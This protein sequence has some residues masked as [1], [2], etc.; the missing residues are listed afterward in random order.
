[1]GYDFKSLTR[2]A[3]EA[4]NRNKFYID[5]EDVDPTVLH[6]ITDLT[7]W[8]RTKGKGSDVREIIAQLFER[9]W[10]E[11]MKEGNANFEVAKSR[12]DFDLLPDRLDS[13]AANLRDKAPI[14]WVKEQLENMT[15]GGPIA[16]LKDLPAIQSTYPD[17]A[18][19]IVVAKGNG[20]WYF[21]SKSSRQWQDGGL[22]KAQGLDKDEVSADNVDFT[23]GVKQM[24]DLDSAFQG[25]VHSWTGTKMG[26]YPDSSTKSYPALRLL[27]NKTYYLKDIRGVFSYY[28]SLDG[29]RM[30]RKF[31][32]K[33][34]VVTTDFTPS[35][36]GLLYITAPT[37]KTPQVFSASLYQLRS[38]GV[39]LNKIYRGYISIK[40][41]KLEL[42]VDAEDLS[43]IRIIK[44]LLDESAI[45]RG[46]YYTGNKQG[47]AISATWGV[48]PPVFL[49][50][51]ETYGLH[52]VRGF[53]TYFMS[54]D[55]QL[56]K[57]FATSDRLVSEDFTP[58]QDGYLLITRQLVDGPSKLISGG[59]SKANM[60]PSLDYGALALETD[61]PFIP[62][63]NKTDFTV[64]KDGSG[65]F[66]SLVT[67]INS[68]GEGTPNKPFNIYIHSGEYNILEELGG[69]QWLQ[70]VERTNSERLGIVV[71]D[72]VNII[73]VGDVV[74]RLE[75]PDE[76]TTVNTAKR[77][78][79][80][81]LWR[82]NTI[83]N[84]KMYT[85]NTRY[86]VHDETNN[87]YHNND[88]K[89]IDCYLEQKGNKTGVWNSNQAYAAG[90]GSG[91]QYLFEN[92]TFKS[93]AIPFSMHD[94]FNQEG[95]TI[96]IRNCTFISGDQETAIRFGS[97]GEN[98]KMSTVSIENSNIDKAI[99]L[100]EERAGSRH[101]NHFKVT[102]GGNT[103]V[104]YINVNSAG[105]KERVE[106]G[107]EVRVLRN[108]G[109][110]EIIIGTP[111]K[112]S[113][114]TVQPLGPSEP[115]LFYGVALD[116]I[117]PGSTGVI[118]YRGYIAKEDTGISSLSAGQKIG[119]VDGR[120]AVVTN[121]DFIG[122]ATDGN[123]ILLKK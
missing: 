121:G 79:V 105:R 45:T 77:I 102:G 115:W 63:E 58:S 89:Y 99:K 119:L 43:F 78:S 51:G 28:V 38:S 123:N 71:P 32:E 117:A 33:E 44:Q 95:N 5:F 85:R 81:N 54:T 103:A 35:E 1:M 94:N 2:Q 100:F 59:L 24:L 92:C 27:A 90:T 21:W 106:F 40:I 101:G 87:S 47:T 83:K 62:K 110:S 93:I 98:S 36:D 52:R 53:F 17:G 82:H 70:T 42:E 80:L 118:K 65:D 122:Y 19:G 29:K 69:D 14:E 60:L 104:P 22:Y 18:Q 37:G 34:G 15:G 31:S 97:Y 11:A 39:D 48:Y 13:M 72:Y 7:E 20:H 67:A 96:K 50:S 120:L 16:V 74:L 61:V 111:V 114:S 25:K 73:G 112:L 76:K 6:Q 56:I 12:G 68:L 75:V 109:Q 64:K 26:D 10:L 86:V 4:S 23:S 116:A 3:D 46:I 66:T 49:K 57:K 91:G 55:D 84:L 88:V 30:I 8:I 113:G 9:T 108:S 107:D 41:P